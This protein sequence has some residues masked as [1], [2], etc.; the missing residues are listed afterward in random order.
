MTFVCHTTASNLSS[1]ALCLVS[2]VSL[3]L[4]SFSSPRS[5]PKIRHPST[6]P[7]PRVP[8][9]HN[10]YRRTSPYAGFTGPAVPNREPKA[11]IPVKW[12][13]R[14]N[15]CPADGSP[16]DRPPSRTALLTTPHRPAAHP[17][18]TK[19][20]SL[21][22]V[23]KT[24]HYP[25]S[26][27]L[28]LL[29]LPSFPVYAFLSLPAQ[30]KTSFNR[31]HTLVPA[32]SSPLSFHAVIAIRKAATPSAPASDK[33][34]TGPRTQAPLPATQSQV[35]PR[36]PSPPATRSTGPRTQAP[37][38]LNHS[39]ASDKVSTGPPDASATTATP[40]GSTQPK[41]TPT[42]SYR[43]HPITA[44]SGRTSLGNH[45]NVWDCWRPTYGC[46]VQAR[47]RL[48]IRTPAHIRDKWSLPL[49]VSLTPDD[50]LPSAAPHVSETIGVS[51][52]VV[53]LK[54]ED[55]L[56]SVPSRV[57]VICYDSAVDIR[58][59]P[60]DGLPSEILRASE[61]S[62]ASIRTFFFRAEAYR[63]LP[64]PRTRP[65]I[66]ST[67]T[68]DI[69]FFFVYVCFFLVPFADCLVPASVPST[70]GTAL[71]ISD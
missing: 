24:A 63:P 33:V 27:P 11:G 34:S 58:V 59:K 16:A 61:A 68:L 48:L 22:A 2:I 47:G 8:T 69:R 3:Q 6:Q 13:C 26:C 40:S 7:T 65:R 42:P 28:T 51:H 64:H 5:T 71:M 49:V 39:S 67:P 70:V 32:H 36:P 62:D 20:S 55:G 37:L 50:E 12:H 14:R 30:Q 10:D 15:S 31:T 60:E 23:K 25:R 41:V 18:V 54:P 9:L 21:P 43:N 19:I 56:P 57:T 4:P 44:A 53:S 45:S 66:P 46:I 35:K 1:A 38:P 29:T 52:L 17:P